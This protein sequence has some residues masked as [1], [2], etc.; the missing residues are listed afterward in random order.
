[1]HTLLP[2]EE[3]EERSTP[4]Y[5]QRNVI[6]REDG[7]GE[8]KLRNSWEASPRGSQGNSAQQSPHLIVTLILE[9][10]QLGQTAESHP[11]PGRVGLEQR[12]EGEEDF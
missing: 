9:H 8:G 1:M 3:E 2:Q 4:N 12:P 11:E 10:P 5:G 7:P 6:G